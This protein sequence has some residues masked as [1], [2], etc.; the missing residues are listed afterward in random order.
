MHLIP[1]WYLQRL[2][3]VRVIGAFGALDARD[4]DRGPCLSG[5]LRNL[6]LDAVVD[7]LE[8]GVFELDV[9]EGRHDAP[10]DLLEIS[11]RE[12]VRGGLP[13]AELVFGRAIAHVLRGTGLGAP[14]AAGHVDTGHAVVVNAID[15][16]EKGGGGEVEGALGEA[17]R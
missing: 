3:F 4:G 15:V 8:V 5:L 2:P 13:V 1:K 7:V 6:L 10:G 11:E 14:E 12:D 16:I 17:V 9:A